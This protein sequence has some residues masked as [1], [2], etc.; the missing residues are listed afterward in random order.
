MQGRAVLRRDVARTPLLPTQH[1]RSGFGM[2]RRFFDQ[3]GYF[4]WMRLINGV[5]CALDFNGCAM[6]T[7]DLLDAVTQII[8]EAAA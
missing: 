4:F 8:P 1:G 2:R 3:R 5:A 7:L 6:R